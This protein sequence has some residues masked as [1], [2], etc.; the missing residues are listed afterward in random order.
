MTDLPKGPSRRQ[1]GSSGL[2]SLAPDAPVATAHGRNQKCVLLTFASLSWQKGSAAQVV[3]LVGQLRKTRPGLRFALMSMWPELDRPGASEL[4]IEVVEPGFSIGTTR[5][6]RSL[7]VLWRNLRCVAW[8]VWRRLWNSGL[9]SVSGGAT[10]CP[11]ADADF[12]VDLSGDSYRD[13]PGGFAAAHWV[14]LLAAAACETPFA[15]ASQSIG[16]FWRCNRLF[17]GWSLARAAVIYVRD[18]QSAR[19]ALSVGASPDRVHVVPDLA[20]S[21]PASS[22]APIWAGEGLDREQFP[23][24]WVAISTSVLSARLSERQRGGD[25]VRD[26]GRLCEHVH[27]RYGGSVFFVPHELDPHGSGLDDR[28]IG[29]GIRQ[30]LMNKPWAQAILGD[31]APHR[32][33]GFIA[34]CDALVASRLHAAIAGLSSG[35]PTIVVAWSHKYAGL[36]EAVGLSELVWDQLEPSTSLNELFDRLWADRERMRRQLCEYTTSAQAQI[37]LMIERLAREIEASSRVARGCGAP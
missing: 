24:P 12:I 14:N 27:E 7:A 18:A 29:E 6:R 31:Y 3:S 35:V 30:R 2:K 33:K 11:H 4:G 23:R 22:P 37:A 5:D 1:P 26:M 25:Y 19:T 21:M 34:E 9:G 20:F 8:G 13:P 16:P 36:M 17:V 28:S 10:P 32:L 15:L